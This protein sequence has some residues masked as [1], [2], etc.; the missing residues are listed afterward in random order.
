MLRSAPCAGALWL[1]GLG[2][3]DGLRLDAP[4]EQMWAAALTAHNPAFAACSPYCDPHLERVG[5][6]RV[7]VPQVQKGAA[8]VRIAASSVNP[9]DWEG[10]QYDSPSESYPKLFGIDFAGTVVKTG[11][12]CQF[13]PGDKVWGLSSKTYAEYML[14]PCAQM[15]LASA[16][17]NLT[18]VATLPAVAITD[19]E[20]FSLVSRDRDLTGKTVLVIG[21]SGGTGHVAIQL[22]KA[23]NAA[24]VIATAG[25]DHQED[26]RS[27]GADQVMDYSTTNFWEALDARSVDVVIHC[28]YVRDFDDDHSAE[29]ADKVLKDGGYFIAMNPGELGPGAIRQ[30]R[31]AV[32]PIPFNVYSVDTYW[33]DVLRS[34]IEKGQL[35]PRLGGIFQLGELATALR[36][37]QRHHPAGK[38]AIQIEGSGL[39]PS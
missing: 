27:F 24:K 28:A 34:Y 18:E 21:G 31:P 5:L 9:A 23:M 20:A 15:G 4:A 36:T 16:N 26:C 17:L 38:L 12:S 1:L 8:L 10:Q 32:K 3:A 39:P 35:R 11:E 19:V 22:A 30:L 7:P 25:S 37:V 6:V 33:F 13:R 2:A 29:H 14:Q